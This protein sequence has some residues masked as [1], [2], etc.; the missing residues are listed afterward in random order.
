MFNIRRLRI[1]VH[2]LLLIDD[3]SMYNLEKPSEIFKIGFLEL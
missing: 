2:L 3:T 1:K